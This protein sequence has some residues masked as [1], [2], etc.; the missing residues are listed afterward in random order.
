M[1]DPYQA[2]LIA[3][4]SGY[5]AGTIVTQQSGP[6]LQWHFCHTSSVDDQLEHLDQGVSGH[7]PLQLPDQDGP[8]VVVHHGDHVVVA[9]APSL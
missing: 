2:E 8:G 6:V 3:E 7:V 9:P 1:T 5:V 4:S